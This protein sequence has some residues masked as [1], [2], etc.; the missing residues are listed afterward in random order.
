MNME[1]EDEY[2]DFYDFSKTYENHPLLIKKSEKQEP[3]TIKE[4][5]KEAENEEDDGWE[6]IDVED[7]DS[8][9]SDQELR[10]LVTDK[11]QEA[12]KIDADAA[13]NQEASSTQ[14]FSLVDKPVTDTQAESSDQ[15]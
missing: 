13:E 9:E 4:E 11:P 2:L 3:E 12:G 1:D 6:D 14:S 8:D 7:E 15:F 10:E 5:E